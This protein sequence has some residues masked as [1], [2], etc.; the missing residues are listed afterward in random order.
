ME[1]LLTDKGNTVGRPGLEEEI[2]SLV[3]A[4]SNLRSYQTFK[5]RCQ[6]GS[7]VY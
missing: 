2:R 7:R 4:M 5:W 6:G 3:L 1:L